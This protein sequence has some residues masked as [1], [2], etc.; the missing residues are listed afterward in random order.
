MLQDKYF[1]F[2]AGSPIPRRT[3]QHVKIWCQVA[4]FVFKNRVLIVSVYDDE[5]RLTFIEHLLSTSDVQMS[6]FISELQD[7]W[8][9]IE[10]VFVTKIKY[11]D[12]L[13]PPSFYA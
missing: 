8:M 7:F 13:L 2:T 5:Q 9:R 1:P 11:W 3:W 12:L 6:L 4:G 10:C